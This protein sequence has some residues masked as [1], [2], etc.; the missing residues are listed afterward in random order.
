MHCSLAK[1]KPC[2]CATLASNS[3]LA[4]S[5]FWAPADSSSSGE[6]SSEGSTPV[7]LMFGS[8]RTSYSDALFF[9]G[10]RVAAYQIDSA[11]SLALLQQS[12]PFWQRQMQPLLQVPHSRP[13]P[14]QSQQHRPQQLQVRDRLSST[15]HQD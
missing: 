15:V 14:W 6:L 11:A 13:P 8:L 9:K 4:L 7:T 10:N 5:A 1:P 12:V 3:G 2:N